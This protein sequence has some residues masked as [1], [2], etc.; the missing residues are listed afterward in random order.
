MATFPNNC[1]AIPW[2]CSVYKTLRAFLCWGRTTA[3]GFS[4]AQ[5]P[6][7]AKVICTT[8]AWCSTPGA[9]WLALT[10]DAAGAAAAGAAAAANDGRRKP[11]S[12]TRCTS[13]LSATTSTLQP[14]NTL[15]RKMHL[16]DISI[17]GGITFQVPS[18]SLTIAPTS[19]FLNCT[20]SPPPP[21]PCRRAACCP[22]AHPPSSWT[23]TA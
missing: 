14:P 11:S 13:N 10:G 2:S 22:P 17:P 19:P 21:S 18:A 23:S 8:L 6:S 7:G 3:C 9:T 4:G 20:P 5:Y 12:F 16:F 15:C 1:A